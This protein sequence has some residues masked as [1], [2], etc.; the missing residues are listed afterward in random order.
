MAT[1]WWNIWKRLKIKKEVKVKRK[2]GA[3]V[4]VA[5]AL[6]LFAQVNIPTFALDDRGG[7]GGGKS[8]TELEK[9][10]RLQRECEAK[11]GTFS[12]SMSG[13][14]ATGHCSTD[15][16]SPVINNGDSN[17]DKSSGGSRTSNGSVS[18]D[19]GVQ[20]N[21]DNSD[22]KGDSKCPEGQ[23]YT[24]IFGGCVD[25]GS[26]GNGV[27]MVLNVI[28]QVLTWGIGIAGTLGIVI[29]GFQ[30]MTARDDANQM[31]KAKNRL[32]QIVIGL[33][34]YAVMWSFLQWL[35]PGGVFGN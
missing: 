23:V 7:A 4:G 33:A 6:V 22:A 17:N 2:L 18:G 32:I 20:W 16:S 35:L 5:M 9:L 8:E 29:T 11:G 10:Q 21:T 30:Y 15:K 13:G 28:L 1:S 34:I 27:F 14:Y 19:T 3:I 26:D 25:S 31:T 24:N 12:G